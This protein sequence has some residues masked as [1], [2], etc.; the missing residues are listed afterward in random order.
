MRWPRRHKGRNCN[1]F[2]CARLTETKRMGTCRSCRPSMSEAQPISHV[3]LYLGLRT[4]LAV[5]LLFPKKPFDSP[6]HCVI[7]VSLLL[8][9]AFLRQ[10]MPLHQPVKRKRPRAKTPSQLPKNAVRRNAITLRCATRY[11]WRPRTLYVL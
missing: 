5:L 2:S 6:L 7:M 8:L 1:S 10:K 11:R 9:Y 3:W 4:R